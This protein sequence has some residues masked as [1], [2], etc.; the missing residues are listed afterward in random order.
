[1]KKKRLIIIF[2]F[3]II[4]FINYF[5]N[6]TYF[7]KAEE[8]NIFTEDFEEAN[9]NFWYPLG[10]TKLSIDSSKSK[11]GNYSL[12]L[13]D[14]TM[15]WHGAA[16]PLVEKLNEET[17]CIFS[18][19]VFQDELASEKIKM[20]LKYLNQD[21]SEVYHFLGKSKVSSGVWTEVKGRFNIPKNLKMPVFYFESENPTLSFN[22]DNVSIIEKKAKLDSESTSVKEKVLFTYDFEE[23]FENWK[24]RGEEKLVRDNKH[25][26]KGDYALKIV[27]RNQ[28][29]SGPSLSLD[30]VIE[31]G[32]TYFYYANVFFEGNE[33]KSSDYFLFQIQY[34]LDGTTRYSTLSNKI[35][36]K[37]IWTEIQG[38]F[39]IPLDAKN[40]YLYMQTENIATFKK[41]DLLDFYVDYIQISNE[42]IEDDTFVEKVQEIQEKEAEKKDDNKYIY[43]IILASI[44]LTVIIALLIFYRLVVMKKENKISTNYIDLDVMTNALNRNAYERKIQ[45]VNKNYTMLKKTNIATCDINF[46]K[47]I[48]DHYGHDKGDD[49]IIKCATL[50]MSLVGQNGLVYRVGGDEF[51]CI[52]NFDLEN[53][54]KEKISDEVDT[55]DGYPFSIALGY[56]SF[57]EGVDQNINDIVKRSDINM[58]AHKQKIKL[59]NS[60]FDRKD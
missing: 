46:L 30:K 35:M 23:D 55:E 20:T 36:K 60:Q 6:N 27:N 40:V 34:D 54:F 17:E 22:V 37:N 19:W 45:E 41:E 9:I 44:L 16:I 29:W 48:N 15:P 50:L 56:A 47:Y 57:L 10:D 12:A 51:I 21:G 42:L 8:S 28:P 26:F 1:M 32:V 43:I 4:I 49:A 11:D 39:V 5:E 38:A 25:S 59:N 24:T 53:I 3:F 14:R 2:L 58:Y 7:I 18:G 31:K 13:K 52:S 33:L